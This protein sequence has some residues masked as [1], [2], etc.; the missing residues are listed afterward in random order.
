MSPDAPKGIG[1]SQNGSRFNDTS[2]LPAKAAPALAPNV[3][4]FSVL[5]LP[6]LAPTIALANSVSRL[7]VIFRSRFEAR[8]DCPQQACSVY[9]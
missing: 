8:I 3:R 7:F 5:G 6:C 2:S 4:N 9:P 1:A